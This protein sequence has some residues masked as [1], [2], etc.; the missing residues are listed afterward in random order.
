MEKK[1]LFRND[2]GFTLIEIITVIIIMGFLAAV[3]VPKFFSMKKDAQIAV[4]KGALSEATARFN[5]AF[6]R[7]VLDNKRAP[8]GIAELYRGI[9]PAKT[10]CVNC[11]D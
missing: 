3:A 9:F 10:G 7:F 4:L 1:N 11:S 5:Q 6:T 8:T 2:E